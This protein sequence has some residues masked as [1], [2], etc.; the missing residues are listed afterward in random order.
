MLA[1]LAVLGAGVTFAPAVVAGAQ[2]G[3]ISG[4]VT[5]AS[6]GRPLAGIMVLVKDTSEPAISPEGVC[7]AAD[8]SYTVPGLASDTYAV[9]F[10]V[11]SSQCVNSPLT[12]ADQ[13]VSA[14]VNAPAVTSGVNVALAPA[15]AIS[16]TVTAGPN[17]GPVSGMQ[18][19][20]DTPSGDGVSQGCTGESGAYA[21]GG[22]PAGSYIVEF[23]GTA[24]VYSGGGFLAQ[25]YGGTSTQSSASPVAVTVGAVSS[26]IGGEVAQD[27]TSTV[28]LITG[29]VTDR[30]T[31][32]PVAGVPV[33]ATPSAGSGGYGTDQF[34][35]TGASGGYV[36]GGLPAGSY[37]VVL[38]TDDR[39]SCG[40]A[41]YIPEIYDG[42]DA[43]SSIGGPQPDNTTGATPVPV[44]AAVTTGGISGTLAPT[45]TISGTVTNAGTGGPAASVAVVIYDTGGTIVGSACTQTDGSYTTTILASGT[46]R[47]GFASDPDAYE[48]CLQHSSAYLPAYFKAAGTLASATPVTVQAPTDVTGIDASLVLGAS[49][50]GTV[51]LPGSA[52]GTG[53]PTVA[54]VLDMAGTVVATGGVD[55]NHLYAVGGLEPGRYVVRF[56]SPGYETQYYSGTPVAAAATAI[57]LGDGSAHTG[58]NAVLVP[59]TDTGSISGTVTDATSRKPVPGVLV[60]VAAPGGPVEGRAVTAANGTYTLSGVPAGSY[61]VAFVD[62]THQHLPEFSQDS[63]TASHATLVHPTAGGKLSGVDAALTRPK[64]VAAA[65]LI[66]P[67]VIPVTSAGVLSLKLVCPGSSACTG[68][69]AISTLRAAHAL[70]RGAERTFQTATT[71]GPRASRRTTP[72]AVTSHRFSVRT[73]RLDVVHFRLSA[74]EIRRLSAMR[75]AA[76]TVTVR[77]RGRTIRYTIM[78]R[79]VAAHRRATHS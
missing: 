36:V 17:A 4:T 31:G 32:A 3:A 53:G 19:Y 15:G 30:V 33:E 46:Y 37:T 40:G 56:S 54:E 78:V 75:R 39:A 28:G 41:S 47:V 69:V 68:H 29:T 25:Y 76:T 38:D 45:A 6:T 9:S 22:L 7:T 27:P 67:S 71:A 59:V 8:G 16:G 42:V 55:Q 79:P 20:I 23:A 11:G 74:T 51:T 43:S 34:S 1:L 50:T 49:I 73:G 48:L 57:S 60:G 12:Y 63:A 66:S 61:D 5:D 35:C 64:T 62:P 13:Q 14:T 44:S 18:I 77:A 58:T 72:R 10:D 65:A 21:I 2:Y 24:C 26:G 70:A 52:P